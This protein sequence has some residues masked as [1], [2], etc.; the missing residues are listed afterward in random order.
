M[1][2]GTGEDRIASIAPDEF[3]LKDIQGDTFKFLHDLQMS[4]TGKAEAIEVTLKHTSL[5]LNYSGDKIFPVNPRGQILHR[6]SYTELEFV[7]GT[8]TEYVESREAERD[9]AEQ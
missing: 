3:V 2:P 4:V 5:F 8:P 7:M 6:E 1:L 9:R